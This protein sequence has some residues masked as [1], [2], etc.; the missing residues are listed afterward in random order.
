MLAV[1]LVLAASHREITGRG[2]LGAVGLALIVGGAVGNLLDLL[3]SPR[4]VVDLIDV[5]I[6]SARFYPFN[7]A[8]AGVTVGAVILAC[9]FW[10]ERAARDRWQHAS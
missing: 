9:V 5:G 10:R 4:G 6:G 3:A 7:I 2:R 1:L 8:D